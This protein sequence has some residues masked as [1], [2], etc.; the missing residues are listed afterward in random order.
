MRYLVV[1]RSHLEGLADVH[2]VDVVSDSSLRAIAD[3]K[4]EAPPPH[5]WVFASAIAWPKGCA[6]IGV[7]AKKAASYR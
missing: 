6:S 7:A 5:P 3:A 4:R 2:C 1:F